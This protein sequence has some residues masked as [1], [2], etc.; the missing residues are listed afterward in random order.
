MDAGDITIGR[1]FG[2]EHIHAIPL[3]Q[4]PYVWDANE[5]WQPLWED[6]VAAT[7]D[8]FLESLD[9]SHNQNETQKY[10]LGAIVLEQRPKQV[11]RVQ[12]FNVIDGQQRLTTLQILLAALRA[13]ATELGKD[14]VSARLTGFIEHDPNRIEETTDRFKIWALPQDREAFERAVSTSIPSTD[15]GRSLH[16]LEKAREWFETQIR[17]LVTSEPDPGLW[18]EHA[19]TAITDRLLLV[20]I[21]LGAKDHPQVIFEALNHRGV[22]LAKADLI[23]NRIFQALQDRVDLSEAE[24]LLN[25][26]WLILDSDRYRSNVVTGRVKRTRVDLLMAYWLQSKTLDEVNVDALF[27]QFLRWFNGQNHLA[28]SV[29]K[30]LH[31]HARA[32][33]ELE[34]SQSDTFIGRL[35]MTMK[36]TAQSTPWP[37]LLALQ[38]R[39]G[40]PQQQR[41]LVAQSLESFIMRRGVAGLESSD[42]NRFFLLILQIIIEAEPQ[43][44][45]A[46]VQELLVS[47]TSESRYWPTDTEFK[48]ALLAPDLYKRMHRPRLKSL[49]VILENELRGDSMSVGGSRLDV[50]DKRLN[51]EHVIP[52]SWHE[53]WPLSHGSIDLQ[54]EQRDEVVHCLG[55]L[56]LVTQRL[57]PSLSNRP[58][59]EKRE[60]LR[61]FSLVR[62]TTSSVLS[63]P[64]SDTI[65]NDEWVSTWDETRIG[66]R[67]SYLADL[68]VQTW[69]R[70]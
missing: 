47:Q 11:R 53:H 32:F 48:K 40:T 43:S 15:D 18:I 16:R 35:V 63:S 68:A 49:L 46:A 70:P 59:Y 55:N 60:K 24:S 6:V 67:G 12:R 17:Q 45:G 28:S 23:K 56:T 19:E 30:E 34:R 4:R 41:E 66:L 33:D 52:Q 64:T 61:E 29:V 38:A 50:S 31:H 22:R 39:G 54:P 5:N 21:N 2:S 3:F 62:L 13:V 57:N 69:T 25:D 42:Y 51:I 9:Q 37:L 8:V 65:P 44:V 36:A 26:Y 27:N 7:R 1:L 20:Q 58:W 14:R 10:F